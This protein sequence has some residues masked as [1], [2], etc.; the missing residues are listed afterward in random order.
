MVILHKNRCFFHISVRSFQ[1]H[2]RWTPLSSSSDHKK[3]WRHGRV[4]FSLYPQKRTAGTSKNHTFEKENHLPNLQF[5]GFHVSFREFSLTVFLKS[6]WLCQKIP[7]QKCS[8]A[9]RKA[10]E[11]SLTLYQHCSAS[12][13]RNCWMIRVFQLSQSKPSYTRSKPSFLEDACSFSG[14]SICMYIH[15]KRRGTFL[16]L[17]ITS[18]QPALLIL[19]VGE[20]A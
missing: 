1:I 14:Y 20:D 18:G 19:R 5:Y 10:L 8:K 7:C 16:G 17:E 15:M 11:E 9:F 13:D 12:W 3:L 6:F 2:K 4:S